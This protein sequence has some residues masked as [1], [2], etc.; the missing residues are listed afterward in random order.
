MANANRGAFTL[1]KFK[2]F[3]QLCIDIG[4]ISLVIQEHVTPRIWQ[5]DR[6]RGSLRARLHAGS[7]IDEIQ[8]TL[9]KRTHQAL[10]IALL[11]GQVAAHMI[12]YAARKGHG[13]EI[14]LQRALPRCFVLH[15]A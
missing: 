11:F 2:Q 1:C 8:T 12:V 14:L 4:R 9:L 3:I 5:V 10:H 13:R 7:A 6:L 15:S